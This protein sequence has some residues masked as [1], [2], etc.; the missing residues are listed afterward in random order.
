MT[1]RSFDIY[2]I[3][4][5]A[6]EQIDGLYGTAFAVLKI[7]RCLVE[8]RELFRQSPAGSLEEEQL[9]E[10]YEVRSRELEE[11]AENLPDDVVNFILQSATQAY[12]GQKMSFLNQTGG[13][14]DDVS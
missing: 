11:Y 2:S 7:A 1:D 10:E 14:V 9:W 3:N 4:D 13:T 6:P 8:S 5:H 12:K